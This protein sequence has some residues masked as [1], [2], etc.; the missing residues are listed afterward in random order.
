MERIYLD[1]GNSG[2][3]LFKRNTDRKW[4]LLQK[5]GDEDAG[6]IA[7]YVLS[8]NGEADPIVCS[9]REDLLQKFQ[10]KLNGRSIEIIR[11]SSIPAKLLDYET[12]ETLG[13][14]RF[15]A[16]LGAF[17]L[18]S[19][20]VI[21]VDA[22]SACTIDLMTSDTVF[23]GGVIM[24]G[25]G[26][27]HNSVRN[28]LPELP[29]V[30]RQIPARWPGKTTVKSLEW[31]INGAFLFSLKGFLKKYMEEYSE[32]EIWLTGGDSEFLFQS[33]REEYSVQRNSYLLPEGMALFS[34]NYG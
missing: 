13:V 18:S 24:P 1:I 6:Q 3:K 22:G 34:E 16:C 5:G 17:S 29:N 15:L 26:I 21:V 4:T 31:G 11:T 10:S 33:L 25:L 2:F 12:P 30:E 32:A 27:L 23:R 7:E 8:L 14:D 28:Q 20:D 19:S 9:V